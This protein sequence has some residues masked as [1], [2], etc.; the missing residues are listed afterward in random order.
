M[1]EIFIGKQAT[2]IPHV[3]VKI[4]WLESIDYIS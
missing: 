3:V 2:E 4:Y 1:L